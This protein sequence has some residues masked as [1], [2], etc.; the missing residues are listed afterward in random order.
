MTPA[1]LVTLKAAIIA[2]PNLTAWAAA[3]ESGQIAGYLAA[4]STFVVWKTSTP[5]A[6]IYD[7]IT[8]AN[9]TPNDAPDGTQIWANRDYACQSKQLNLQILLQGV[10]S[11]NS[12]KSN[13]RSGLQDGLSNV[14]SGAAGVLVSAGWFAV[15]SIMTRKANKLEVIFATG[16]G[17]AATPGN[18]VVE[19]IPSNEDILAALKA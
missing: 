11:I 4:D 7:N 2:D 1:Q 9:L 18:L 16:I 5:T 6:D 17:T 13:I 19:G 14:P 12:S 15:K 3:N 8:W 10:S